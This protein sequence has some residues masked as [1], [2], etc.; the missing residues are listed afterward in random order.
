MTL[1]TI[2]LAGT[3]LGMAT[4]LAVPANAATATSNEIEALKAQMMEMQQR[5]DDLQISYGNKLNDIKTKQDAVEVGLSN[6]RPTIRTGDGLFTFAIRG[7]AHLDYGVY[8]QGTNS[9]ARTAGGLDSGANFRRAEIGFDGTFLRDWGYR[10]NMQWGDSGAERAST[11]KDAY[12]SYNGI[13]GISIMAGAIQTF[14]TLDDSTSSNDITFMERSSAANLATSLAAGDGRISFGARG[15]TEN[16]YLSA[17]YTMN[18]L[19]TAANTSS[20]GSGFVG[21]TAFMFKPADDFTVHLGA[22]GAYKSDPDGAV[23]F[24]DRP[25]LRVD[26]TRLVTSGAIAA[27]SAY[28]YG[29][30]LAMSYGPFKAQGEYYRYGVTRFNSA[31]PDPKFNAWYLQASWV[32]TGEKYSYDIV[33]AAYKGVNPV[34]LFSLGGGLGAWEVAARYSV[35]D[36]N[37]N[38]GVALAATPAGG[39]RGGEQD[40]ITLGLNWYPNRNI[41]MMF[42]YQNIDV[43]RLSG[44][45]ANIGHSYDAVAGRVQ[46]AF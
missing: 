18:T 11:I 23:T 21:R 43:D 33:E 36:L 3:A 9:K 20:E 13:K 37:F 15:N 2:L 8:N 4:M 12:L 38:E 28:T 42:Q 6:G 24:Q 1:K 25:E 32:I 40:I 29:P 35:T 41:R 17:F 39:V 44:A 14:Q 7:R 30:E 5:I 22:S 45:G 10:L 46:F 31:L 34:S 19:G 26:A 16:F 27:E